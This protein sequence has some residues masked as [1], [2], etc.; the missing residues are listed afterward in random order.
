M[1]LKLGSEKCGPEFG[2][3]KRCKE[4]GTLN[5]GSEKGQ[6]SIFIRWINVNSK[7]VNLKLGSEEWL[8]RR[9]CNKWLITYFVIQKGSTEQVTRSS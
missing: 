5:E 7:D 9:H 4:E 3:D 6:D 8:I 1:E 2:P